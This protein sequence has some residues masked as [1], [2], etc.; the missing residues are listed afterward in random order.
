MYEPLVLRKTPSALWDLQMN[1]AEI[2]FPVPEG[3]VVVTDDFYT[4]YVLAEQLK[5]LSD[6]EVLSLG[7]VRMNKVDGVN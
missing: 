4:R 6:N 7:T 2:T 3:S 1:R 5:W